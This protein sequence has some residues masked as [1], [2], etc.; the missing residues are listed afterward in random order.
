VRHGGWKEITAEDA[1]DAE[2]K[3]KEVKKKKEVV[4][5]SNQLSS[6]NNFTS[7]LDSAISPSSAV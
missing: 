4:T 2:I 3:T 6:T 7:R 5:I 1:K